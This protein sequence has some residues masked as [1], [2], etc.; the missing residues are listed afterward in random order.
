[1]R[2]YFLPIFFVLF[3]SGGFLHLLNA[4]W[5]VEQVP[6]FDSFEGN[7]GEVDVL[8]VHTDAVAVN[9]LHRYDTLLVSSK[10]APA[11]IAAN[12]VPSIQQNPQPDKSPIESLPKPQKK[13]EEL[14]AQSTTASEVQENPAQREGKKGSSVKKKSVQTESLSQ[15]FESPEATEDVVVDNSSDDM[16]FLTADFF[17]DSLGGV[18]DSQDSSMGTQRL[19]DMK[20]T[21]VEP[22]VSIAT[23]FKYSANPLKAE[24]SET[25]DITSL[26]LSL[27]LNLKL[28][29]F[30]IGENVLSSP[31]ITFMQ[32]RTLNDPVGD[33]GDDL[34]FMNSDV[35]IA[36][37]SVPFMLPNE[38][39]LTLAH[40]YVAPFTVEGDNQQISYSNS[41]SLSFS[42]N[43]NLSSGHVLSFSSGYSYTFSKSDTLEAQLDPDYFNFLQE[44]MG[45][46]SVVQS[47]FP[48]NLQNGYAHSIGL[49]YLIPLSD[50]LQISPS[51]SYQNTI[52]TEGDNRGRS[53]KNYNAGVNASL[54]L[55]EIFT[56]S[57]MSNY[58]WKKSNNP[59]TPE[60]KDFVSGLTL[61]ASYSF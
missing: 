6:G 24:K 15:A 5:E 27:N 20:T 61:N 29:D 18:M 59:D 21:L 31:S 4:F 54:A 14:L 22:T 2:F 17:A 46:S 45:G 44:L 16:P 32:I 58:S 47:R 40:S 33:Q 39:M 1:M 28:G 57:V 7:I 34:S 36:G 23:S 52:F 50:E 12:P 9:D 49:N 43:F 37:L 53:D 8:F 42:K 3:F 48:S 56:F 41:P 60:F 55:S 19:L 11:S 38:F 13:T 26:D 25:E 51:L 10:Q 35:T 30:P